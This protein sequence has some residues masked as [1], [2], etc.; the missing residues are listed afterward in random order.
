MYFCYF[1]WILQ[2]Y[3]YFYYDY[4]RGLVIREGDR[5][6]AHVSDYRPYIYY[7]QYIDIKNLK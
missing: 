7:Y 2:Y 3:N 4:L 5:Y 6:Y 1:Y